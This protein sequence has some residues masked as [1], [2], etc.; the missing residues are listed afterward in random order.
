M[1]KNNLVTESKNTLLKDY[2]WLTIIRYIFFLCIIVLFTFIFYKFFIIEKINQ[3]Q[4][5]TILAL[6]NNL[7][8][9][10]SNIDIVNGDIKHIQV[11]WQNSADQIAKQKH[12]WFIYELHFYI[13]MANSLLNTSNDYTEALHF[14]AFAQ[15]TLSKIVV[16]EDLSNLKSDLLADITAVESSEQQFDIYRKQ[17]LM[18]ID[19]VNSF[20]LTKN[21]MHKISPHELTN[22]IINNDKNLSWWHKYKDYVQQNLA[23]IFIFHE[24]KVDV[25]NIVNV[26]QASVLQ[27]IILNNLFIA[28]NALLK[29]NQKIFITATQ[30]A[31]NL[32]QKYFANNSVYFKKNLQLLQDMQKNFQHIHQNIELHS[33]RKIDA[34]L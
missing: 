30:N 33:L 9:L 31:I 17:M 16:I 34:I 23:K 14:L 27:E 8:E 28:Q 20:R 24:N 7:H 12:I 29:N 3:T 6:Q 15:K 21:L 18:V 19:Y 32:L 2:R 22:T 1:N 5:Q 10:Q 13:K 4:Q 26:Q 11:Q 25:N